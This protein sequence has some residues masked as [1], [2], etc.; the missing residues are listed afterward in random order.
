MEALRRR[1]SLAA[2]QAVQD[3][4]IEGGAELVELMGKI[5]SGLAQLIE[6]PDGELQLNFRGSSKRRSVM[7]EAP[8]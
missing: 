3:D 2:R 7:K 8:A 6:G 1:D 4:M 5:E